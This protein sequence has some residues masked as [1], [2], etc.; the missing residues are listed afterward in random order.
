MKIVRHGIFDDFAGIILEF[1]CKK[2]CV[3]V[4]MEFNLIHLIANFY[5]SY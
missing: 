2:I 5:S 3:F 4:K 1:A